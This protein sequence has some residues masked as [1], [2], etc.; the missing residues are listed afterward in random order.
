M[1]K[2]WFVKIII[3]AFLCFACAHNDQTNSL[4]KSLEIT[5]SAAASLQNAFREI[6][7]IYEQQT[8]VKINFNFA[9]SG[10]LQKQIEQG[11]PA[12]VFASAGR[13]QMDA[14]AD[15]NLIALETRQDFARN[16]IVLI[17]PDKTELPNLSFAE[18]LETNKGKIALGNPKT[19]PAGQYAEQTL[20]NLGLSEKLQSRF[21][22][23]EDVRQ[24]LDYVERGEVGFGIVYASDV[25]ADNK[26]VLEIARA[27]ENSH[28]P[29]LY[30]IAMIK[31]NQNQE[32]ARKFIE[33]VLSPEGQ[34]VLQ[35]NRFQSVK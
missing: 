17:V 4:K 32:A 25:D 30:P 15:K 9:S 3:V 33:L 19:V 6:A 11:A 10:A 26:K 5:V 7:K 29:I 35:E 1:Q 20:R 12:D 24:V 34:R 31:N 18:Y 2:I 13:Q 14:L 22:F 8:N 16:E 27:P 28:E 23:A 21:V